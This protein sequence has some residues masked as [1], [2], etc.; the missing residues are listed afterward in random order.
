MAKNHAIKTKNNRT[1]LHKAIKILSVVCILISTGGFG[2]HTWNL[3]NKLN[4]LESQLRDV[5]K[6]YDE[7]ISVFERF[8]VDE[9]KAMINRVNRD[10]V[11]AGRDLP[12]RDESVEMHNQNGLAALRGG[13]IAWASSVSDEYSNEVRQEVH[14]MDWDQLQEEKKKILPNAQTALNTVKNNR[15]YALN[16]KIV[17]MNQRDSYYSF[18]LFIQVIG[19]IL[20][21]IAEAIK[22]E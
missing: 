14:E 10:V 9:V 3:N 12:K 21:G 13:L 22:K 17:L 8:N 2:I 19:I 7:K 4:D 15:N 6:Q 5:N 20:G 16:Q 11:I 18:Y 1:H